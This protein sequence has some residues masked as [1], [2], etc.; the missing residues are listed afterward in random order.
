MNTAA[1]TIGG[2]V[3]ASEG[4]SGAE[5]D[6]P[7]E[8]EPEPAGSARRRLPDAEVTV[9]SAPGTA[10]ANPPPDLGWL[11]QRLREALCHLAPPVG[12]VTV[13][14]VG[15]PAMRA[16]HRRHLGTDQTTDVLAFADSGDGEPL[17][18]DIAVCL[19][20][21]AGC[22]AERGLRVEQ[23]LL[24]YAL[25]GLLHCAGGEDKTDEGFRAM[26]AEEDR[27]LSAIGVGA[28]FERQPA[29]SRDTIHER[30]PQS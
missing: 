17:E 27:I 18:A 11:Q 1:I 19:D 4:A 23:E 20:V 13:S 5:P 21:A 9:F 6:N 22:A 10:G 30:G 26:H 14:V 3:E 12:R 25:H 15:A 28:V 16:L 2:S 7:P 24:L 29:R 8:P